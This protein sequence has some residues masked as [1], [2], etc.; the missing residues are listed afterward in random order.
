M[1]A[2]KNEYLFKQIY[3]R[4][5]DFSKRDSWTK[6]TVDSIHSMAENLSALNPCEKWNVIFQ[7][8]VSEVLDMTHLKGSVW[9]TTFQKSDRKRPSV[10]EQLS[11]IVSD[12][13]DSAFTG[14]SELEIP[15]LV[16]PMTSKEGK[17]LNLDYCRTL[18]FCLY[19]QTENYGTNK[20]P[21]A[22]I[23]F[24]TE[25][26][27]I[28]KEG[29]KNA[30][31]GAAICNFQVL[32]A[33]TLKEANN[34]TLGELLDMER[35]RAVVLSKMQMKETLYRIGEIGKNLHYE[36][37]GMGS[38][39]MTATALFEEARRLKESIEGMNQKG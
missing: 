7:K 16:R 12:A 37:A 39:Q 3:I 24:G 29:K 36:K 2:V 32:R 22:Y 21:V 34:I 1:R 6:E 4:E 11:C 35:I 8:S 19:M 23:T 10:L 17:T 14:E 25:D 27:E 20:I 38:L 26:H 33:D 5:M 13:M 31:L 30:E 15:F 28:T 18:V 9:R